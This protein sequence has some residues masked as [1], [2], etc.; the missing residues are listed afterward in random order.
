[1]SDKTKEQPAAQQQPQQQFEKVTLDTPVKRGEEVINVITIRKP[2]SGELRGVALTDVL[3][4]D[5][6]ALNKVLPR[7]TQPSLSE[8]EVMNLDPADLVQIGTA[9]SGFLL[10]RKLRGEMESPQG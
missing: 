7:I 3:Q 9:L 2:R 5:V 8:M 6:N 4:M 10:S 1:M